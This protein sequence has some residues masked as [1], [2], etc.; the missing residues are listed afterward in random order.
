MMAGGL[1]ESGPFALTA[2]FNHSCGKNT[3][4]DLG[5]AGVF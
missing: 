3:V 2:C 1:L 4:A 5:F